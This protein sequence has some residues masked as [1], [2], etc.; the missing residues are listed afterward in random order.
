MEAH[1]PAQAA[2]PPGVLIETADPDG[3][4]GLLEV[5]DH[6]DVGA[7]DRDPSG[8]GEHLGPRRCSER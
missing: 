6:V 4:V 2:D 1:D 3:E 7:G 5:E 8:L